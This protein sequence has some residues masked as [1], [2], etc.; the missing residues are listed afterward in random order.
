MVKDNNLKPIL[1]QKPFDTVQELKSKNEI[2]SYEEF[3]ENY[4]DGNLN[5]NDLN[6]GDV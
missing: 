5:Y 2:P 1:Q 3:M 4:Q 6:S